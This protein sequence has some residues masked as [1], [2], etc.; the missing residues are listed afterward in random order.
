MLVAGAA[1]ESGSRRSRSSGSEQS[2]STAAAGAAS[3]AGSSGSGGGNRQLQH[4]PEE[5]SGSRQ[6]FR[7]A[8]G[9]PCEFFVDVM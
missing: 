8:M 3:G 6:S 7:M 1:S 2:G 4:V 5:V 9:N